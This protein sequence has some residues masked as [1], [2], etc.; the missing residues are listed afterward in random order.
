MEPGIGTSRD[1]SGIALALDGKTLYGDDFSQQ[2]IDEWF[3]GEQEGYFNLY[4]APGGVNG[5]DGAKV[6]EGEY[7]FSEIVER[8]LFK[9]LKGKAFDSILGVGCADGVEL[10][11][12]LNR[13]RRVTILEPSDGFAATEID[14]VPVSY[15]K[16]H[17]S[18]IMPFPDNSF[19]LVV[20]FQ[21]LHHIPNVST[22]VREMYRVLKPGG[23]AMLMEPCHSMGD[24]RSP[25]FGLTKNERG[26][27]TELFRN[28]ASQAGFGI[29]HEARCMFSLMSRLTHAGIAPWRSPLVVRVDDML[30]RLP[31]WPRRYHATSW[32][33]KLRPTATA[34]VLRKNG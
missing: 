32:W 13:T 11:P 4:Y 22:I 34:L 28:I 6:R 26:I 20:C 5:P 2:E 25:R 23:H 8:H 9:W 1:D 17:A 14:G 15:V 24:W 10:R 27:P 3:R 16:P 7:W 18:G 29:E 30:C 33:H 21:A 19:E 31:V 12:L